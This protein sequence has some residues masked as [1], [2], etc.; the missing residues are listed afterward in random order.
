MP[1]QILRL[2][3]IGLGRAAA[4]MLPSLTAHGGVR[5]TAAAD[6]NPAARARFEVDFAG[7]TYTTG[8]ELCASS[9]VD[10]VYVATP[11]QNHASDVIAAAV[12]GKHILVEKP[13]ALTV[14]ECRL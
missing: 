8:V 5:V 4:Q 12:N 11:H 9:D 3:V 10:A 1:E 2:G 13:M 14:E 6:P 7:H